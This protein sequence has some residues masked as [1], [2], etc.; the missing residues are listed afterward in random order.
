LQA[1]ADFFS[2]PTEWST[3]LPGE[4]LVGRFTVEGSDLVYRIDN[5]ATVPEPRAWALMLAGLGAVGWIRRR[6]GR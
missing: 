3:W 4:G 5:V 1:E 6:Q 2:S